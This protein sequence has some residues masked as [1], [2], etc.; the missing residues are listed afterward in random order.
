M[1]ENARRLYQIHIR[2]DFALRS[3]SRCPESSGTKSSDPTSEGV[4]GFKPR[5]ETLR[6]GWGQLHHYLV[7]ECS[8]GNGARRLG[9]H[10]HRVQGCVHRRDGKQTHLPSQLPYGST[11][12]GRKKGNGHLG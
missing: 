11:R 3:V 1:S 9:N 5:F 6:I 7:P 10:S 12:Q 8:A 4:E 2:V